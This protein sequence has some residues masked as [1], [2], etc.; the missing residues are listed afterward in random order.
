MF[1]SIRV[2]GHLDHCWSDWITVINI[3]HEVDGSSVLTA[4][5]PDQA[6]LITA[7]T[8]LNNLCIRIISVMEIPHQQHLSTTA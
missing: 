5:F 7:L 1:Y 3:A 6:G 4:S 8:K 2:K